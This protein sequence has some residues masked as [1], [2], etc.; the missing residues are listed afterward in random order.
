M[1]QAHVLLVGGA[2]G[3]GRTLLGRLN[4]TRLR[5]VVTCR[6]DDAAF[7]QL[8]DDAGG[9]RVHL[10]LAD[11]DSVE[12]ATEDVLRALG[13]EGWL[14]SIV[15]LASPPPQV[16]AFRHQG[17]DEFERQLRVQVSGPYRLL[18]TLLAR[19]L[20][21][22]RSGQVISV[23]SAALTRAEQGHAS[24]MSAYVVGKAAQKMLLTEMANEHKWLRVSHLHPAHV[25]TP[26]LQAFDARYVELLRHSGT[27]TAPGQVADQ[28]VELLNDEPDLPTA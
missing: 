15:L 16:V 11:L 10:D 23:S 19:H 17:A 12:A 22:R 27:I 8:V 18:Q 2:G 26:M 14:E 4:R 9:T 24:H 21:A 3:I 28:I 7:A 25:D 6:H 20:L 5:P 1:H 13:A